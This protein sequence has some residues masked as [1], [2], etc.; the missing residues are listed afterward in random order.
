MGIDLPACDQCSSSPCLRTWTSVAPGVC[1]FVATQHEEEKSS[2]A[3]LTNVLIELR[4]RR[5]LLAL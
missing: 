2:L 5:V 3:S 1:H 4:Q